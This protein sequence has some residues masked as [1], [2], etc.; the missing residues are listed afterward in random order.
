MLANRSPEA[1]VLS[2]PHPQLPEKFPDYMVRLAPGTVSFVY[3]DGLF[4]GENQREGGEDFW[5]LAEANDPQIGLDA[6]RQL[7]GFQRGMRLDPLLQGT[8]QIG[9]GYSWGY[10][11][12]TSSEIHGAE[13][14]K[15]ISLSG[16][17][18]HEEWEPDEDTRYSN[19]VY[20]SDA[21]L[22]AQ[23]TGQVWDGKVPS[24]HDAFT[25][26]YY[27]VP[28]EGIFWPDSTSIDDH[29]LPTTDSADNK[30]L[31]EDAYEEVIR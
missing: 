18:M 21:L 15:S 25:N 23:R 31:L 7:A 29:S 20:R 24:K 1:N 10:Q 27:S 13:Y 14:D 12:L 26:Y 22:W 8:E 5:R 11:N 2:G 9:I 3:K 30:R 17:G 16:A 6:G 4:P 19:F 28:N